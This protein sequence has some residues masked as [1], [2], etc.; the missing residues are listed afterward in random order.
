[1]ANPTIQL[2]GA[3]RETA[4]RLTNGVYYAWGHHGGCNCGNLLQVVTHL[5]KEEIVAFAHTGAGEWTEIA[6]EYCPVSHVP[7]YLLISKLE[8]IGLN[9]YRYSPY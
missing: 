1:M 6:E 7:A 4:K 3:L 9:P 8:S 2:I 5:T